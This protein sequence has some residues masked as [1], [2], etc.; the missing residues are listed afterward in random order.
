MHPTDE[1]D[2]AYKLMRPFETHSQSSVFIIH[3]LKLENMRNIG[4]ISGITN[5]A[6]AMYS[7]LSQ[8]KVEIKRKAC[9]SQ[10]Q[11]LDHCTVRFA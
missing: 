11:N 8:Q 9:A 1:Q 3:F 7:T 10:H 4:A 2:M 6:I 5:M